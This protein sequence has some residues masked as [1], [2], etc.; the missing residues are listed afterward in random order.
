MENTQKNKHILISRHLRLGRA[1]LTCYVAD[2]VASCRTDGPPDGRQGGG[3]DE[4][5]DWPG[6]GADNG[7]LKTARAAAAWRPYDLSA[8]S[9]YVE[10]K[11]PVNADCLFIISTMT[12]LYYL[13]RA[14]LSAACDKY[15]EDAL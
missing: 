9:V 10:W 15:G 7:G 2:G 1:A 4:S 6:L 13:S 11:R 8:S 12:I 5:G 14:P 3:R